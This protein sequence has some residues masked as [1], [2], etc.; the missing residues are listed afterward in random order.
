MLAQRLR[1]LRLA[2]GL[3]LDELSDFLGEVVTKQAL[4]KYEK[5]LSKPSMKVVTK[6]AEAFGIKAAHLFAE[7]AVQV[8]LL[9]YRKC[10]SL[11]KRDEYMVEGMVAQSLEERIALQEKVDEIPPLNLPPQQYRVESLD[12]AEQAAENLREF[13]KVG[14]GPIPSVVG[15]LEDQFIH[16]F[17]IATS[18]EKFDGTSAIAKDEN[19]TV[20]A[21]AAV[22]REGVPGERQRFS[23]LHEVGHLVLDIADGIDEEKASHR[24]AGAFLAPAGLLRREIGTRRTTVQLRELFML[25]RRFGISAQAIAFRLRDLSIL[26]ESTY[27][28]LCIQFNHNKMRKNEPEPLSPEEPQWLKRTVLRAFSEGLITAD[29]AHRLTDESY[30]SAH[31]DIIDRRAF[32]KLSLAERSK[33]LRDQAEHLKEHY[34]KM[35]NLGGGDFLDY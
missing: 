18:S 33:V 7:P 12:D 34:V 2:R 6:I 5:G 27:K 19:G 4:S 26:N 13:W 35:K 22:S 29:E 30:E 31:K 15:L 24:F 20:I 21:A 25:K 32:M 23:L 28:W 16:V 10:A 3:S 9:A 1:Q 11:S 8:Q 17:T 14:T